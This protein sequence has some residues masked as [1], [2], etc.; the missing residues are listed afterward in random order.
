MPTGTRDDERMSQDDLPKIGAPATR[1]LASIGVTQ[2]DEVADRSE[3]ELLALHG[4][5]QRALRILQEALA[6]RGQTMHP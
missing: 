1:A 2:L 6:L 5:G 4:F 3:S